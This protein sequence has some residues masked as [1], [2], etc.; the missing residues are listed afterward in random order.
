MFFIHCLQQC[1]EILLKLVLEAV[2]F[3]RSD[4]TLSDSFYMGSL[5]GKSMSEKNHLLSMLAGVCSITVY[6]F[7]FRGITGLPFDLRVIPACL[8]IGAFVYTFSAMFAWVFRK[9]HL[10]TICFT[11]STTA[12]MLLLALLST[13]GHWHE[14]HFLHWLQFASFG[15]VTGLG[16]SLTAKCLTRKDQKQEGAT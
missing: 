5:E 14:I 16:G 13:T 11:V 15:A 12:T 8:F 6:T 3:F 10:N 1:K 9:S 4:K 7:L 2:R